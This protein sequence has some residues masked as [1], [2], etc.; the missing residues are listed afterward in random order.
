MDIRRDL[1]I[2]DPVS[3]FILQL[4]VL[5]PFARHRVAT[6]LVEC[7]NFATTEDVAKISHAVTKDPWASK[8]F[9]VVDQIHR[10]LGCAGEEGN[11]SEP[12]MRADEYLIKI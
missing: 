7:M 2:E 4:D 12:R 11:F 3:F 10:V 9:L 5:W 8:P 1:F 6:Y